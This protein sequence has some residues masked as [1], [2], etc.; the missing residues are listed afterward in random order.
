MSMI[1]FIKRHENVLHKPSV[2]VDSLTEKLEKL[3]SMQPD[4]QKIVD[5]IHARLDEEGLLPKV[6]DEIRVGDE[7]IGYGNSYTILI[8]GL[9]GK[10]LDIL[11]LTKF[12][13]SYGVE[14]DE[15]IHSGSD[16]KGKGKMGYCFYVDRK[17]LIKIDPWKKPNIYSR[18]D[19]SKFLDKFS[20]SA[21]QKSLSHLNL[22]AKDFQ[23]GEEVELL[24]DY[25][26]TKNLKYKKGRRGIVREIYQ[27]IE[28][29]SVSF[30]G[31]PLPV[32]RDT[33]AKVKQQLELG[34]KVFDFDV[35]ERISQIIKDTEEEFNLLKYQEKSEK[36]IRDVKK[37]AQQ[38]IAVDVKDIQELTEVIKPFRNGLDSIINEFLNEDRELEA[39]L[40]EHD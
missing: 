37:L 3:K 24:R 1:E 14:F 36:V 31:R 28:R 23:V 27:R 9:K 4:Y 40:Y 8:N 30:D 25:N 39:L 35:V 17:S 38:I 15:Y 21:K 7:V 33:I 20:E 22:N 5:R 11:D 32:G 18:E 34:D 29:F 26:I 6:D 10:V 2:S 12:I 16:C 13:N 19:Y